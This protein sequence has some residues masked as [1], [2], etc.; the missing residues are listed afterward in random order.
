[1][2]IKKKTRALGENANELK[3]STNEKAQLKG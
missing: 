2:F 1:M 3:C